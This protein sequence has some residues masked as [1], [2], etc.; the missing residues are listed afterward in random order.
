MAG[1]FQK[2]VFQIRQNRA[3]AGDANVVLGNALNDV[4]YQVVAFSA[5]GKF[6][7]VA[8]DFLHTRD[9]AK[10]F[11]GLRIIGRENHGSLRAMLVDE[12]LRPVDG[13]NAPVLDDGYAVA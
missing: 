5:D 12:I 6:R 10:T 7:S 11:G 3:V 1:Q 13:D 4:G 9:G 8:D 2:D